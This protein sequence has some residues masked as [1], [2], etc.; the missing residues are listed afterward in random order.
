MVDSP[1][2]AAREPAREITV[3][4]LLLHTSGLN[5]RTSDEY[6]RAQVRS[7]DIT[8]PRF[9]SNIVRVPLMEHR[10]RARR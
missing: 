7:R 8:L 6:K 2:A 5:H 10:T 4:D 3:Q 9:I 1:D